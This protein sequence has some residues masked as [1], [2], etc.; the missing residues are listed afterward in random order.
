VPAYSR[1]ETATL[2]AAERPFGALVRMLHNVDVVHGTYYSLIWVIVLVAGP[3]ELATRLPSAVATAVTAAVVFGL[4]R[5]LVS[6][7]AGLAAGLVFA[8]IPQV[9]YWGQTARPYALEITLAATA[10]YLLVRAMQAAASGDKSYRWWIAAY[11]ASLVSLGY[12]QFLGLLV[13][14]AHLIPV[15][16]T[17]LRRHADGKGS[18]LALG[19]LA[20]ALTA[21]AIV[22]PVMVTGLEQ[23]GIGKNP[24]DLGFIRNL[25]GLIGTTYMGELAG[26]AVVCAV[27]ISACRGRARLRADWPGDMIALCVPWLTVPPLIL[28]LHADGSPLYIRYLL[29]CAPAAAVLLGSGLAVLGWIPGT[30]ILA[31][32]AALAVPTMLRVRTPDGHGGADIVAA[33]KIIARDRRP[34]D[35]LLYGAIN[36]TITMAYP[37]GMRQLQ[38]IEV[39]TTAIASGTL[40]GLRAPS[41]V[42]LRRAEAA[43]RIWLV[44]VSVNGQLNPN[45]SVFP[46]RLDF[47]KV[48]TWEFNTL[49]L[50]LYAR[51]PPA[52]R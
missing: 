39:G 19:W 38:N 10:S 7:R 24:L 49:L 9:S 4:A 32:F 41:A 12:V 34:G 35:V 48:R 28:I 37:Y 20:A 18:G 13:I 36:E 2:S 52:A 27:A 1:D 26:V 45:V 3:G 17:W 46:K 23:R 51:D 40:G 5:R 50:T 44:Q 8:V 33:D 31:I 43:R 11:G 15:A 25:V 6:P 47:R 42:V 21:V 30:A 22:S 16:R 29:F 14:A